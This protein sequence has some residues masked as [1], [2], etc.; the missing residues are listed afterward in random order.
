ML[1]H[2][3]GLIALLTAA[4]TDSAAYAQTLTR[5]GFAQSR[6]PTF[7]ESVVALLGS[8]DPREQAWGAF[9]ASGS[10][11]PYFAPFLAEVVAQ[12]LGDQS[13]AAVA[14]VDI[15]L[16]ALIQLHATVPDALVRRVHE[17]L[18]AP[19]MILASRNRDGTVDFMRELAARGDQGAGWFAAANL[20]LHSSP[21]G[22]GARPGLA[23]I[24]LRGLAVRLEV[25]ISE[26]GSIT[27]GG[28][29]GGSSACGSGAGPAPGLPP[30]PAYGL[31]T[32]GHEGA[33]V[34]A[35]GPTTAYY[36]RKVSPAG[37]GRPLLDSQQIERSGRD[38]LRYLAALAG[39]EEDRLP[40]RGVEWHSVRPDTEAILA[41][42]VDGLRADLLAR[43]A[44]LIQM[45]IQ[46]GL[47]TVQD[48]SALPP[49]AIQVVVH[50]ARG[51]K[52]SKPLAGS[53]PAD[54]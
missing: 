9:Y 38:R 42:H 10:A 54:R 36:N 32:Y 11:Q 52:P 16:D 4:I 39:L 51:D 19:A 21:F 7:E 50:D 34:L 37:A 40:L 48:G 6:Q 3:L 45:L 30:W 17:H 33:V 26:T 18:P 53:D 49:L 8:S 22:G 23:M 41:R 25:T 28:R 47:M 14:A 1:R 31:T 43:H 29:A 5:P 35:E 20:L 15:A 44:A 27:A 2:A 24:L 46:Y 13:L 12:R